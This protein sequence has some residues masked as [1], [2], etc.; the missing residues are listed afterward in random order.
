MIFFVIFQ[1]CVYF[2]N[3]LPYGLLILLNSLIIYKANRFTKA[4]KASAA[5]STLISIRRAKRKA[6]MTKTIIFITFLYIATSLPGIL[7]T[8]YFYTSIIVLDAGSVIVS[9]I[10]AVQFSYPAL[11]FFILF[12][13]N[14]LFADEVKAFFI[15]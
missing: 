2:G 4:Q 11:N 15:K 8:G 13:S 10:N 14:K 9:L 5:S 1:I 3:L 12:F 6:Q 7:Q